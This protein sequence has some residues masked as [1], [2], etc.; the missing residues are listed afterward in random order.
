MLLL[1]YFVQKGKPKPTLS[2]LGIIS[3]VVDLVLPAPNCICNEPESIKRAANLLCTVFN[4]NKYG[5]SGSSIK[6]GS[7]VLVFLIELYTFS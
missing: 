1:I 6:L 2:G 5:T 3:S 4:S 7:L